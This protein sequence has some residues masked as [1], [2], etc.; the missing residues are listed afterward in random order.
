MKNP[1][2]NSQLCNILQFLGIPPKCKER[3]DIGFILDSS[4]SLKS[5]Y[6]KE[7]EFLKALA[8]AFD[9]SPDGSR[10]GVVTFSLIAE[11]SIKMKDHTSIGEL[12][13]IEYI[14]FE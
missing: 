10:A 6:H 1:N 7:K 12:Y 2:I 13:D 11:H 5:K 4:E 8:G 3:V 14:C 9:I